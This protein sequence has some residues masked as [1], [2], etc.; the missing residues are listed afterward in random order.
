MEIS[1]HRAMRS[2]GC[3]MAVVYADHDKKFNTGSSNGTFGGGSISGFMDRLFV[4]AGSDHVDR[5]RVH[6]KEKAFLL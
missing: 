5:A 6:P 2:I 3:G 1:V 4:L